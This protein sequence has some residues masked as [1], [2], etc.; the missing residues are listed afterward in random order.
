MSEVTATGSPRSMDCTADRPTPAS[1][2]SW[3]LA[4]VAVETTAREPGA[5]LVQYC[6]VGQL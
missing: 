5:E 6:A 3:Y 1:L 4:Q 2:A